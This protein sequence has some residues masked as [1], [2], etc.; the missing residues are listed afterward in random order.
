MFS[1]NT[2]PDLVAI[3]K[4]RVN[5][6]RWPQ[7]V[8]YKL[9]CPSHSF[10]FIE[11]IEGGDLPPP[12]ASNDGKNYTIN[13]NFPQ[14]SAVDLSGTALT[15]EHVFDNDYT[16]TSISAWRED[17]ASFGTDIDRSPRTAGVTLDYQF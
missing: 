4:M 3:L 6:R 13:N 5:Y 2:N 7:H 8:W 9:W 14:D 15:V 10:L 12:N 1:L 17:E 16:L 11:W